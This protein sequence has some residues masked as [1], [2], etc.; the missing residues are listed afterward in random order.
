VFISLNILVAVDSQVL[1]V[2]Q[3]HWHATGADTRT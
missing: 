3:T 2:F 1:T